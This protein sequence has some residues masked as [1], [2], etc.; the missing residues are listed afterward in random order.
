MLLELMPWPD[1]DLM[2]WPDIPISAQPLLSKPLTA[3]DQ[4]LVATMARLDV[5]TQCPGSG[6]LVAS[7]T[8]RLVAQQGSLGSRAGC[9]SGRE[10]LAALG[11]PRGQRGSKRCR[12]KEK[13]TRIARMFET[14]WSAPGIKILEIFPA[15]PCQSL[16]PPVDV[17]VG[18]VW[19]AGCRVWGSRFSTCRHHS[20]S[21][22]ARARVRR[23]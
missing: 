9:A 2:P 14:G 8:K 10:E 12:G 19:G 13:G 6:S 16:H 21:S 5:G 20:R 11:V 23:G 18:A 22:F 3:G 1:M 4:A 17:T 7:F 15:M